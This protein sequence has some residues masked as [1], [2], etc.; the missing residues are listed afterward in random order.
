MSQDPESPSRTAQA[1]S[2]ESPVDSTEGRRV[3][4]PE[5]LGFAVGTRLLGDRF[6]VEARL[7]EGGMGVVYAGFDAQREETVALKTL[8][9]MDPA[10]I[11]HLKREF[12]S[13]AHVVHPNLVR[14]HELFSDGDVWFFTM[15]LLQGLPYDRWLTHNLPTQR[16]RFSAGDWEILNGRLQHTLPQLVTAIDAI[17]RAGKLHCDLKPSNVI[18]SENGRAVLLDF[19]LV[20]DKAVDGSDSGDHIVGTPGYMAPEQ[21]AGRKAGAWSDYYALGVILFEALTGQLPFGGSS[22]DALAEK[23]TREAPHALDLC[24]GAPKE[25]AMLSARLLARDPSRRPN[26]A[27]LSD[28]LVAQEPIDA[29]PI[30]MPS[31]PPERLVGRDR[32][33]RLLHD[34]YR[35]SAQGSRPVI[36]ML[37]GES[38]IGKSALMSRF[39]SELSALSSAPMVLSSRCYEQESVPF[40]AFDAC[41]DELSRQLSRLPEESLQAMTPGGAFALSRLFPVLGRLRTFQ[42]ADDINSADR[43]ELRR[44]GFRALGQLL[45]RLRERRP[46]LLH[47]DD[48]QW[49]D[50]DSIALLLHILR[51]GNAPP[52]LFVG[53][54]RNGDLDSLAEIYEKLGSDI[55]VHFSALELAPLTEQ[56]AAELGAGVPSGALREA[57]GNPFL[58][59]E[60]SRSSH[61]SPSPGYGE[62]SLL[63]L[64]QDRYK[65]LA[66]PNQRLLQAAVLSGGP[67]PLRIAL[68]AAGVDPS[69]VDGLRANRLVRAGDRRGDLECYHDQIRECLA[70][71]LDAAQSSEVHRSLAQAWAADSHQDPERVAHHFDQAGDAVR[72]AEYAIQ[73]A[74]RAEAALGFHRA[75]RLYEWALARGEFAQDAMQQFRLSQASALANAGRSREAAEACQQALECTD[76][77][78]RPPLFR[79]AGC[80]YLQ[81]GYLEEGISLVNRGLSEYGFHVAKSE[82]GAAA[83]LLWERTKLKLRAYR[84]NTKGPNEEAIRR[85]DAAEQIAYALPRLDPLRFVSL[86]TELART[87]Y[88]TGDKVRMARGMA[89]EAWNQTILGVPQERVR[90]YVAQARALC[91]ETG[92]PVGRFWLDLNT[93]NAELLRNPDVS[94]QYFNACGNQLHAHP[95]PSISFLGPILEWGRQYALCLRGAYATVAQAMPPLL[96]EAWAR[97]DLGVVPFLAGIPGTVARVAVEDLHGQQRDLQRAKDAWKSPSFS[98]Q[99]IMLAQGELILNL[100]QENHEGAAASAAE[101]LASARQSLAYKAAPVRAYVH[102]LEAWASL[103]KAREM[104]DGS[105]ERAQ[106][107]KQARTALDFHESLDALSG[108]WPTPL[109]AAARVLQGDRDGAVASLR[110]DLAHPTSLSRLPSYRA[111]VEWG[112]GHLLGGD[113]GAQ[114]VDTARACLRDSGVKDAERFL[115]AIAPGLLT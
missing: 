11:Y 33:L 74:L 71:T 59:R 95:D 16:S 47:I 7:G 34:A 25:L 65:R 87:A 63:N 88:Q 55:R 6:Q 10:G 53:S 83:K 80:F 13:L 2:A 96:D 60:L 114:L 93:A 67:I 103:A 52:L 38:G 24:P 58:I 51:Q 29:G 115:A 12:R 1:R 104:R 100:Y 110:V 64:L 45:Q 41:V 89:C 99:A 31:E 97:D 23:Q 32:E 49:S 48:L 54:H 46:L 56:D 82:K 15:E 28:E 81:G 79:M 90:P 86:A 62:V 92:D 40:N 66:A 44:R 26:H 9:R 5:P 84:P 70:S 35:L 111:T 61:H 50:Q 109:G 14:L 98:W 4:A 42:Q 39:V 112:L 37:R 21:A 43:H 3:G 68:S 113:E 78:Q 101:V 76:E 85:F 36:V 30:G 77:A 106:I 57:H 20:T 69:A 107:L 75:A 22:A 17:H 18:I 27:E 108:T 72:A 73:A 94:L 105:T 8:G 102:Y 19:G 91:D